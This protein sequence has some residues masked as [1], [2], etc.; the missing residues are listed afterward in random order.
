M[1]PTDSPA[2]APT[3]THEAIAKYCDQCEEGSRYNGQNGAA[4]SFR[5]IAA[6][7]RDVAAR[8]SPEPMTNATGGML[9]HK[10]GCVCVYCED[11]KRARVPEPVK[12]MTN[13]E[14]CRCGAAGVIPH[15][16]NCSHYVAP[17]ASACT[18]ME[19]CEFEWWVRFTG[20]DGI[21]RW[22]SLQGHWIEEPNQIGMPLFNCREAAWK[23]VCCSINA[24]P[25]WYDSRPDAPP[26]V[27]V[28][29]NTRDCTPM[30]PGTAEALGRAFKAAHKQF[31]EPTPP[32]DEEAAESW[33]CFHCNTVFTNPKHAAEHFGRHEGSTPACKLTHSE[34][35]LV[36]Y[37]RK[38]ERE[39]ESYRIED[40]DILRAW[41][42]KEAE[43]REAVR[44]AEERGY[45]KGV[46]EAKVMFEKESLAA[47]TP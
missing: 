24:P 26:P 22:L 11:L 14:P 2:P 25:T 39:L 46:Q 30:Q 40:S 28:H 38:L 41:C 18:I 31:G 9:G 37:I 5:A 16:R 45:D 6:R 47:R 15:H 12:P 19:R 42:S 27:E 23:A 1:P 44:R 36:T 43:S 32:G 13:R 35:H 34:G 29:L 21:Y 10:V 4:F 33:K 8:Q 17:W 7:I 3:D 20:S